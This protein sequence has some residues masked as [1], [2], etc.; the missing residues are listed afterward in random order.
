[1]RRSLR[2]LLLPAV[3]VLTAAV[4]GSPASAQSPAPVGT[5]PTSFNIDWGFGVAPGL[6][7]VSQLPP[8]AG[9]PSTDVN[10][11][12]WTCVNLIAFANPHG[13]RFVAVDN[14]LPL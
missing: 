6:Y 14:H 10:G 11:D 7:P 4:T 3:L 5:C 8:T 9:L 1:M 2:M 13:T 12:G